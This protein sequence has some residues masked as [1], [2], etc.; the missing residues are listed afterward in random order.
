MTRARNNSS[1]KYRVVRRREDSS[2]HHIVLKGVDA[3]EV[4]QDVGDGLVAAGN[5]GQMQE[6]HAVPVHRALLRL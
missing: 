6:V 5:R 3:C 2:T 4:R 1:F